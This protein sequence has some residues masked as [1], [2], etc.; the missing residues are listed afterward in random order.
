MVERGGRRGREGEKWV[1]SGHGQMYV[2]CTQ[3][4]GTW[5]L[6]IIILKFI[7]II[8]EQHLHR[9]LYNTHIAH[10]AHVHRLLYW[11]QSRARLQHIMSWKH[12]AY[13][14]IGL[15]TCRM[16]RGVF[17]PR[18]VLFKGRQGNVCVWEVVV[19]GARTIHSDAAHGG[20][21]AYCFCCSAFFPVDT[22]L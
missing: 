17:V 18:G 11:M 3:H 22:E 14:L 2:L 19:V 10:T 8:K 7:I 4:Q 15:L 20:K 13:L 12:I 6:V 9:L 16:P 5:T 1:G 21:I